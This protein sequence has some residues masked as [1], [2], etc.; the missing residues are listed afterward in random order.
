MA[1]QSF[2]VLDDRDAFIFG[3]KQSFDISEDRDAFIFR[4]MQSFDVSEN[5]DFFRVEVLTFSRP[6][7]RL[8]S[9]S[10]KTL[11]FRRI[12]VP[13]CSGSSSP[14]LYCLTLNM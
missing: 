3:G 11:T 4:V 14:R 13:S 12:V 8:S 7:C 2:Y 9:A 5:R 10:R 6:V 1:K